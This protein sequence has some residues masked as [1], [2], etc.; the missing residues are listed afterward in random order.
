M[1]VGDL[2]IKSNDLLFALYSI[3]A[4]HCVLKIYWNVLR[5]YL[6]ANFGASGLTE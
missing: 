2:V 3:Q 6:N 4:L 5:S 1:D